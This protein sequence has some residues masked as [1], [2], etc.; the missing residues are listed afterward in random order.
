MEL[1]ILVWLIIEILDV[2]LNAV[3]DVKV[4]IYVVCFRVCKCPELSNLFVVHFSSAMGQ[5][6]FGVIH[7]KIIKESPLFLVR[8]CKF[9]IDPLLGLKHGFL[10]LAKVLQMCLLGLKWCFELLIYLSF[11]IDFLSSTIFH[12]DLIGRESTLTPAIDELLLREIDIH[13]FELLGIQMDIL[14]H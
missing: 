8:I 2:P 9:L 12:K 10:F 3:F 11:L 1:F 5:Y 6:F 14:H 4:F 7:E 13:L